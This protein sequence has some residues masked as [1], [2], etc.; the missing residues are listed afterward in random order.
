LKSLRVVFSL[1]CTHIHNIGLYS[2]AQ[3][4]EKILGLSF[5][6]EFKQNPDE[7]V[8]GMNV[9]SIKPAL[10]RHIGLECHGW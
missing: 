8:P 5:F 6:E 3:E 4:K 7:G 10:Q 1:C 9:L 2:G